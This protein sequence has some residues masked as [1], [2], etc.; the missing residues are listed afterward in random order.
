M[1]QKL[2]KN[3]TTNISNLSEQQLQRLVPKPRLGA[4][5]NTTATS[6]LVGIDDVHFNVRLSN[7]H[8]IYLF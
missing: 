1:K 2:I 5:T 6:L 3:V 8:R 7:H 4:K